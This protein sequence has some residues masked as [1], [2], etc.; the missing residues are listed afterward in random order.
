MRFS[1]FQAIC[2]TI[3]WELRKRCRHASPT[4]PSLSF[5]SPPVD[6]T[7][8]GVWEAPLVA[9][10]TRPRVTSSTDF[11]LEYIDPSLILSSQQSGRVSAVTPPV[12]NIVSGILLD[13][14]D[15]SH[16]TREYFDMPPIHNTTK[17]ERKPETPSY[18]EFDEYINYP[19]VDQDVKAPNL[20]NSNIGRASTTAPENEI[21]RS[22]VHLPPTYYRANDHDQANTYNEQV[23]LGVTPT[24]RSIDESIQWTGRV[25]D[26]STSLNE[27]YRGSFTSP[28]SPE[29]QDDQLE[30]PFN[31]REW[32]SN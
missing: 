26:A 7:E 8:N 17:L 4:C 2:L 11:A 3:P 15:H 13:N 32:S 14:I 21:H 23:L 16:A 31:Y 19:A 27:L 12:N 24:L 6:L 20:D 29:I 28:I 18:P 30:E 25:F 5:G 1:V 10:S 9:L 22:T